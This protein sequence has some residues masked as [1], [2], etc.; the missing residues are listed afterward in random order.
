MV[1]EYNDTLLVSYLAMFTNCSRYDVWGFCDF[2][3]LIWSSWTMISSFVTSITTNFV[4]HALGHLRLKLSHEPNRKESNFFL[5]GDCSTMNEL[6]DKFNTA[7]D[8]HSRRGGR[9]AFI[10]KLEVLPGLVSCSYWISY[11]ASS[12]IFWEFRNPHVGN[13][14]MEVVN[15]VLSFAVVLVSRYVI[16]PA[17][18]VDT[19]M[20][21]SE[22]GRGF[23][24]RYQSVALYYFVKRELH[25]KRVKK[26]G[27]YFAMCLSFDLCILFHCQ[28]VFVFSLI[29]VFSPT[30]VERIWKLCVS[31]FYF[32]FSPSI[33]QC[34]TTYCLGG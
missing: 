9:T 24:L 3:F 19:I 29:C 28:I 26:N 25:F 4:V 11:A 8:R 16:L 27:W 20:D 34:T 30:L 31:V 21:R 17:I 13:I 18:L 2:F 32:L 23:W 22:N 6:V 14:G 12:Y 15:F 33:T 5:F 1:Q 10:W 7:Y